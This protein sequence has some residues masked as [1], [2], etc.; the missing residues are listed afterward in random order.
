MESAS[1]APFSC[2]NGDRIS[3]ASVP[4]PISLLRPAAHTS[5][6]KGLAR[7]PLSWK[8]VTQAWAE[9]EVSRCQRRA[10]EP[11]KEERGQVYS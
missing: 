6:W 8:F 5:L 11:R 1:V 9:D 7:M 4:R 3:I 2:L 10:G